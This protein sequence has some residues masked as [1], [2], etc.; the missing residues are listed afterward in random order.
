MSQTVVHYLEENSYF[1]T[2]E[3]DYE[4][5]RA[6]GLPRICSA[7]IIKYVVDSDAHLT[8]CLCV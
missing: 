4:H 5:K 2:V 1:Q 3:K 6:N 7:R 8:T